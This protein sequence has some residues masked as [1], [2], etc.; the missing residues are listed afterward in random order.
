[1]C[2]VCIDVQRGFHAPQVQPPSGGCQWII[3]KNCKCGC[4]EVEFPVYKPP[5]PEPEKCV[6]WRQDICPIHPEL[7]ENMNK[8]SPAVDEDVLKDCGILLTAL[9]TTMDDDHWYADELKAMKE[10]ITVALA[11]KK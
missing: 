11:R 10:R 6:C 7:A 4:R 1:M 9:V 5:V 3:A 2:Q 8:P